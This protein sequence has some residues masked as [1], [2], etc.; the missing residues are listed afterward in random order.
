MV[1][2]SLLAHLSPTAKERRQKIILVPIIGIMDF[3][4]SD[5]EVAAVAAMIVRH[6]FLFL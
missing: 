4:D 6:N 2:I 1:P 5:D 3:E